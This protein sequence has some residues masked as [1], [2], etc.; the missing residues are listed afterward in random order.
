M[1]Q[2][3]KTSL[4]TIMKQSCECQTDKDKEDAKYK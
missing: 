1:N 4:S 2:T 3:L